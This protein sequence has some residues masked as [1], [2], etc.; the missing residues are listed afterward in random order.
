M[1][2]WKHDQY[3]K[4][5]AERTQPCR[6][7]AARVAIQNPQRVID[8]GCGP[9]NSTEVLA[10]LWPRAE[11]T[12]LDSS[13]EMIAKARGLHPEWRWLSGDIAER[14]DGEACFN[15][16][17]S[18]AAIQWE[19]DHP[20]VFPRLMPHRAPCAGARVAVASNY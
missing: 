7:L 3:L 14:T 11:L 19:P 4:C 10:A 12:G 16:G 1:P 9:G 17:S 6:D 8:L 20:G 13:A 5:A 18:T 2:T 15:V